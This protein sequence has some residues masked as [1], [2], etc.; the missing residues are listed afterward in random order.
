MCR[1]LGVV[2]NETTDFRFSLHEAE[3]S[4]AKLSVEHA[5]GWGLAVHSDQTG[6]ELHRNPVRAG[7]C[8]RFKELA[9]HA[10]GEILVAHI[11]KRT[12]GPI[13]L[14]N[15]HPFRRG[16]FIFAHNGT[17]PG[18]DQLVAR[19]SVERAAE[20]EGQ[21]DSERLFAF[22]LSRIDSG[23]TIDEALVAAVDEAMA[24]PDMGAANF[25][26]SN[27]EA[28]WAFRC[29]R[30]LFRLERKPKD[31]VRQRRVAHET[32]AEL[33]TPWSPRRHAILLASEKM[34]DEP[35][36]EVPEGTLLRIDSGTPRLTILRQ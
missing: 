9:A 19:T 34:T 4:L 15:T 17:I 32:E 24:L 10:K 22:L 5:D 11:R 29:G 27:G 7:D 13:G 3:R 20:V 14:R 6:W 26:F 35:W 25:L 16:E 23:G 12:V 2:C 28:L 36:V 1:L 33:E 18:V 21:T 30:T 8:D 31:P